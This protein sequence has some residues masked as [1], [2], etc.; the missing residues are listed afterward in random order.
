MKNS[1]CAAFL[2]ALFSTVV[3]PVQAGVSDR[4]QEPSD[5]KV[6]YNRGTE[7]Y[8]NGEFEAAI[9]ELS[10]AIA[11]EPKAPDA[12]F[13]R[14]LSFRRQHRIDEAISDFSEA[15]ALYP[16]QPSYYLSRCNARIVKGDFTGA[17]DDA[18]QA[19]RFLPDEARVYFMRGLA[20][21][22]RGDLDEALADSITALQIDPLYPD[23]QRLLRETLIQRDMLPEMRTS[24]SPPKPYIAN[25]PK[26]I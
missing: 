5:A 7:H 16:F 11:L 3:I 22:F 4:V 20:H 10:M 14:G 8:E 13:N 17:I 18:T 6:H 9:R 15:I 2:F 1:F 25:T 19:A 26:E 23:A 21:K 24:S 12:Y